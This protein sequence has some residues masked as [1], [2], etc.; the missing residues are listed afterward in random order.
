MS[1]SPEKSQLIQAYMILHSQQTNVRRRLSVDSS[2]SSA[3]SPNS[4]TSSS[5]S[6]SYVIIL[7]ALTR[8][9]ILIEISYIFFWPQKTLPISFYEFSSRFSFTT[10]LAPPNEHHIHPGRTFRATTA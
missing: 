7:L 6:V 8:V 5:A 2:S 4:S 3:S 1:S 9:L 10:N